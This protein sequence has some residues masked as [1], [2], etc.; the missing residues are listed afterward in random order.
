M[1]ESWGGT[2]KL[3][4]I[5]QQSHLLRQASSIP[6]LYKL[7]I[8][9]AKSVLRFF[10]FPLEHSDKSNVAV[11]GENEEK[12]SSNSRVILSCYRGRFLTFLSNKY[13]VHKEVQ[14]CK[15]GPSKVSSLITN[16]NFSGEKEI[17]YLCMRL[18]ICPRWLLLDSIF[19]CKI[20][21]NQKL[22]KQFD[23][24]ATPNSIEKLYE[25]FLHY[26]EIKYTFSQSLNL[27]IADLFLQSL[28]VFDVCHH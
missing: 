18:C 21:E 12:L 11:W 20:N 14:P 25:R 4:S 17:C 24:S 1:E 9:W 6:R 8:T 16:S 10:F 26:R 28:F 23:R 3:F 5:P 15:I 19:L 13:G 2:F 7:Y 22:N 27:S